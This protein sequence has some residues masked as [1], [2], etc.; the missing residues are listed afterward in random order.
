MRPTAQDQ[1]LDLERLMREQPFEA[2][3][4]HQRAEVLTEMSADE[5]RRIRSVALLAEAYLHEGPALPQPRQETQ[6]VLRHRLR[7]RTRWATQVGIW[8]DYRLPVWQAA[9]A[10]TL[11]VLTLQWASLP[12]GNGAQAASGQALLADSTHYDSALRTS[13]DPQDTVFSRLNREADT[14]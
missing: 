14:L 10:A 5:Y 6:Q 3:N 13:F 2:L 12:Q 11:L 7:V 9:A 8:L 1:P 4:L